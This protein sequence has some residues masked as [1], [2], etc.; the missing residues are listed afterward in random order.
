MKKDLKNNPARSIKEEKKRD[1]ANQVEKEQ[2]VKIGS[3]RF[4]RQLKPS[5]QFD[6]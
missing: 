4:G 2:E 5:K 3:S 6:Y 1:A